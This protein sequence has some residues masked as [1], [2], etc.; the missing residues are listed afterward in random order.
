MLNELLIP[1]TE[2]N[3]IKGQFINNKCSS[4]HGSIAV[5]LS[6]FNLMIFLIQ[7]PLRNTS[8][9]PQKKEKKRKGGARGKEKRKD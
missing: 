6:F 7:F 2:L 4:K 3:A 5:G 9:P 8:P 1:G